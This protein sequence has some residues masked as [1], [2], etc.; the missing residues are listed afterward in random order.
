MGRGEEKT[1]SFLAGTVSER[2]GRGGGGGGVCEEGMSSGAF[3]TGRESSVGSRAR[4]AALGSSLFLVGRESEEPRKAW[5]TLRPGPFLDGR[6][7]PEM[8]SPETPSGKH[9]LGRSTNFI[10]PEAKS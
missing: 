10:H 1:Q 7:N 9:F 6:G 3:L 4:G 2:R 5:R 8:D